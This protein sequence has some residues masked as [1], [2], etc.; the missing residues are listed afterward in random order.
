[1]GNK[2][3]IKPKFDAFITTKNTEN[4]QSALQELIA[5]KISDEDVKNVILPD[6]IRKFIT[7]NFEG[8]KITMTEVCF[9]SISY[10]LRI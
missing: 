4:L 1:M 8:F 5:Q 2:V 7:D 9:Y 6:I 3:S 10:K